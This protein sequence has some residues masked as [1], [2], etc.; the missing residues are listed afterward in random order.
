[1]YKKITY[2]ALLLG[3]ITF[4]QPSEFERNNVQGHPTSIEESNTK[5]LIRVSQIVDYETEY[6]TKTTYNAEGNPLVRHYFN[7]EGEERFLETFTYNDQN[8]L[9][10]RELKNEAEDFHLIEDYVYTPHGYEV[11]KSENELIVLLSTY[12]FD[13]N[14]LLIKETEKN[15]LDEGIFI[16]KTHSYKNKKITKTHVKYDGGI[17]TLEF[18]TDDNGNVI[19][20]VFL[21]DGK[22]VGHRKTK[23]YDKNNNL[24][25]EQLFEANGALKHT[26][27]I[28]YQY[29]AQNNWTKRT[30]YSNQF[31][32]PISNATRTLKY[33]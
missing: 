1:M 13:E 6:H 8:Q 21:S 19:E 9:V 4:G 2:I 32:Q 7:T 3:S 29:D 20:E 33:K 5:A 27:K 16:D 14:R 17:Y 11:T 26:S 28:M 12:E 22:K 23:K 30:Q 18:K 25:E 15:Q 24:I 31:D 10:T